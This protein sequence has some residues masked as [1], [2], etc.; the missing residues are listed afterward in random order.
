MKKYNNFLWVSENEEKDKIKVYMN[1]YEPLYGITELNFYVVHSQLLYSPPDYWVN[2]GR[3]RNHSI[4]EECVKNI[5]ASKSDNKMFDWMITID[6]DVSKLK[7]YKKNVTEV[8]K[9]ILFNISTFNTNVKKSFNKI[10]IMKLEKYFESKF[11]VLNFEENCYYIKDDMYIN[12]ICLKLIN[13]KKIKN[14]VVY[15]YY[16]ND[17]IFV[18][19]FHR[20]IDI[21]NIED[22][23]EE[24]YEFFMD[25]INSI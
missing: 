9:V 16:N 17:R 6:F 24:Y 1:K 14:S 15:V 7:R 25:F 8:T 22:P 12:E 18:N 21:T 2:I 20:Y 13:N 19:D 11:K 23:K 10:P 4:I 3:R 5:V